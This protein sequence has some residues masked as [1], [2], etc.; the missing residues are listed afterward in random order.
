[1]LLGKLKHDAM[2]S[3]KP[4]GAMQAKINAK[5]ALRKKMTREGER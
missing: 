1:M 2:M 4:K 5:E 3:L